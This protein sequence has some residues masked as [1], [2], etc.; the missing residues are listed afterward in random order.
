MKLLTQTYFEVCVDGYSY[1]FDSVHATF[2]KLFLE[3]I[4]I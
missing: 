2:K 3:I 1:A 4:I